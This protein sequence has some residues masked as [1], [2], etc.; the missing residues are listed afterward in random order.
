MF[1][2]PKLLSIKKPK[3]D[4]HQ[5]PPPHNSVY[6]KDELS[7]YYPGVQF[8]VNCAIANPG[9]VKIEKDVIMAHNSSITAVTGYNNKYYKP[10]IIIGRG[11]QI[12]SYNAIAAIDKITIGEFVLFGPYVHVNDH[13]HGYKDISKAIMHQPVTSKGPVVIEDGCWLGFGA[14]ILSGVTIGRNSVIGANSLVTKDI[15]PFCV[16]VGNPAKVIKRYNFERKTWER[17]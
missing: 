10:S 5:L 14:H 4:N 1:R 11:T 7:L 9:H 15:P 8:G 16:A 13:S 12:G 2:V 6:Y 3:E 17:S